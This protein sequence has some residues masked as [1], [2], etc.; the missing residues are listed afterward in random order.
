[1]G[2]QITFKPPKEFVDTKLRSISNSSPMINDLRDIHT[3]LLLLCMKPADDS[4]YKTTNKLRYLLRSL[5]GTIRLNTFAD[6]V[7]RFEE[8]GYIWYC[9]WN[10][11]HSECDWGLEETISNQIEDFIILKELVNTPDWFDDHEKFYEKL[12]TIKEDISGFEEICEEIA[13]YEV[14][15]LLREFDVSNKPDPEEISDES[16]KVSD[17]SDKVSDESDKVSDESDK[18]SGEPDKVSGESD[19]VSGESDKVSGESD[20]VSDECPYWRCA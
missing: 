10:F 5:Y 15:D 16:D 9:G 7:S 13:I 11:S 18:V 6:A 17:E 1:M 2:Y 4:I 8:E 3:E 12:N 19:K 14:M 20:K